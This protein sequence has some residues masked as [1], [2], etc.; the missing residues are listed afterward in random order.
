MDTTTYSDSLLVI[1]LPLGWEECMFAM[2]KGVEGYCT[3]EESVQDVG[4]KQEISWWTAIYEARR[5]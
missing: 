1:L 2:W 5:D 3:L 4:G